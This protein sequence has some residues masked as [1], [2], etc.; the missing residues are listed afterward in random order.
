MKNF[1]KIL[2]YVMLSALSVVAFILMTNYYYTGGDNWFGRDL[3][4]ACYGIWCFTFAVFF[5]DVVSKF[6]RLRTRII[7]AITTSLLLTTIVFLANNFWRYLSINC[8]FNWEYPIPYGTLM[9]WDITHTYGWG[10]F[11]Y[12]MVFIIIFVI[13]GLKIFLSHP[14]IKAVYHGWNDKLCN[15]LYVKELQKERLSELY[16]EVVED[17]DTSRLVDYV[18]HMPLSDEGKF[19]LMN[20]ID[21]QRDCLLIYLL[22][23]HYEDLLTKEEYIKYR[24]LYEDI[25]ETYINK[26]KEHFATAKV[27]FPEMFRKLDD[28]FNII[29][30]E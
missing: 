30:R 18:R 22:F 15:W 8:E 20:F 6:R 17:P 27:E 2:K 29:D 21:E 7:A 14:K 13:C 5:Y 19:E 16:H 11:R 12:P 23:M 24:M 10:E 9:K 28:R 25:T 4:K 3:E 1:R 26:Q